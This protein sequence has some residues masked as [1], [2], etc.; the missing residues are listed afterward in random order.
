[1]HADG[2]R[3]WRWHTDINHPTNIVEIAIPQEVSADDL[4]DIEAQFALI[5]KQLKRAVEQKT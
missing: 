5:V 2:R 3:Y 4:A 1:M